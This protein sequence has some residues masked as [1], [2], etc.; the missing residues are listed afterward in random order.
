MP[1]ASENAW[2]IICQKAGL[3]FDS[4]T[5]TDNALPS[6]SFVQS[7]PLTSYSWEPSCATGTPDLMNYFPHGQVAACVRACVCVLCGGGG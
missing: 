2:L 4:N 5:L 6:P 1:V 7:S 3:G